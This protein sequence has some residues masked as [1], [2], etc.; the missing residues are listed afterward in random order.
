MAFDSP[1]AA[2]DVASMIAAYRKVRA[3]SDALAAPL[4]D[5]DWMLQPCVE[6][7]PVKWNLAHT[8]WFFETFLLQPAG[9]EPVDPRYNYLFNSYYQQIGAR[10]P[11][12]ERGL[13]SRPS[14]EEVR[15]YRREIDG[16]MIDLLEKADE[17]RLAELAPLI[18]L[19]LAHE[20]QHQEL[21]LTDVLYVFSMQP[22]APAAYPAPELIAATAAP[23]DETTWTAFE[24]GV[25]EIGHA[26]DGF[27]FDNEGPRHPVH[28]TP[29]ALADR[30]VTN[31]DYLAF[32]EDGG[33]REPTLWLADGWDMLARDGVAAPLYW[34]GEP[35]AFVEYGWFGERPLDPA[36]PVRH[37]SYYE[38]DAYANWT[39]ARLPT[40]FEWERA[41]RTRPVEGRFLGDA[42]PVAAAPVGDGPLAD[43]FGGVWEWTRSAYAPYPGYR[44]PEGAVGEYNGKFMSNQ[45]VLRGGSIAT[46]EGHIR[47]SYRNFFYPGSRW[48]VAGLRLARDL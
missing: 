27:H 37:L 20:E 39:G 18:A 1:A 6:A 25:F 15:A 10:Q 48:Q 40:E 13:L 28:T 38:A 43:I 34:R 12:G 21:L 29:F 45:M 14:A 42:G 16:R 32:I 7:S 23:P 36:A 41:A 19:G 2:R 33:Y 4:S 46:P 5:E 47:A 26:G 9:V 22:F 31:A 11:R 8:S 3:R 44:A 30:L 35:G 24:P 17:G